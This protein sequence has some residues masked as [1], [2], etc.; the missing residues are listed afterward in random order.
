MDIAHIVA[1]DKI[2]RAIKDGEFAGIKGMGKPLPKDDAAHL[3][4]SLRMGYRILKNAG[5]AE[6]EGVLKKELMTLDYLI[7]KCRNETELDH[8]RNKRT[9]KQVRLDKLTEEKAMFSKPA[10]SHYKEK[11]Y[12]RLNRP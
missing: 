9:E 3:P 2:K 8:L 10:S 1:E 11:V 5:I 7:A 4:E 6:D 12:R